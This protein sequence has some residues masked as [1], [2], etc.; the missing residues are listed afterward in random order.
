MREEYC[1]VKTT[2]DMPVRVAVRMSMSIPGVIYYFI[3]E[4]TLRIMVCLTVIVCWKCFITNDSK[5]KLLSIFK[6]FGHKAFISVLPDR[7]KPKTI[8]LVFVAFPQSMQH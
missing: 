5:I 2:P 1:R 4:Y 8:K 7:V 6:R 3:Y